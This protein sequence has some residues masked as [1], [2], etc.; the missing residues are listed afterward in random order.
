MGLVDS[1]VIGHLNS[2]IYLAAVSIGSSL[3]SFLFMLPLFLRMGT[4]G[5]AA[6]AFGRGDKKALARNLIQPL[7]IA[8]LLAGGIIV[9][10]P[11]MTDYALN[12]SGV[13]TEVSEQSRQFLYIRWLSAPAY[14]LNMVILGW[15]LAV[16]Y[17]KAPVILL[18]IGNL[19]N[20]ILE[21][22]LVCYWQWGVRGSACATVIAEYITLTAGVMLVIRVLKLQ[23]INCGLLFCCWWQDWQRLF[24][25]N[26]NIFLRCLLL[27]LTFLSMTMIGSHLGSQIVAVNA[28]L[29]MFVTFT[30]YA[31]DGFAYAVE[32]TAGAAIGAGNKRWLN[33]VWAAACRQAMLVAGIFTMIYW[34][35]GSHIIKLMTSLSSLQALADQY[36]FWQYLLPVIGV[37]CYLLDG[38][39]IGAA[40]GQEMRNS[41]LV[42]VT[43][44][45]CTLLTLPWLGNHALWLA[46]SVFLLLRGA[47]LWKYWMLNR[48]NNIWFNQI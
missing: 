11:V 7:F 10:T 46:I 13:S 5:L 12:L 41:M 23:K 36:L 24:R 1:I 43:G 17:A 37:W 35:C 19:S 34:G 38:L 27:Q 8:L 22:V 16:Q 9:F 45:G 20:I 44:Y 25:L 2:E 48:R 42:A 6:Q 39:F 21:I 26:T 40:R 33:N 28:I 4:T 47:I 14:L 30:A 31:L 15:L 18:L 3:T 32:A 29:M